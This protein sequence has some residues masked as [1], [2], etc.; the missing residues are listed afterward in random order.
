MIKEYFENQNNL[1]HHLISSLSYWQIY[2]E[3]FQKKTVPIF[4]FTILYSIPV[5][6][7]SFLEIYIVYQ[8]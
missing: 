4:N 7:K 6:T 2:Y 3:I 5:K 8:R 1:T